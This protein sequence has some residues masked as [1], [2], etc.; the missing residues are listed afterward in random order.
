M[1]SEKVSYIPENWT[2]ANCYIVHGEKDYLIDPSIDFDAQIA[3]NLAAVIATHFHY[4]H[5]Q[6]SDV[7]RKR[8]QAEFYIPK[9][10]FPLLKDT[11]ANCSIMFGRPTVFSE[12]EHYFSDQEKFL[13]DR[14]LS[15]LAYH[16]PGHSPGSSVILV[17][18]TAEA[19]PIALISGDV[20]FADSIGRTDL[21]GGSSEAMWESLRRLIKIM[22]DL[23][24][25]LP[26]LP[27][28]GSPFK[29]KDAFHYNPY[30]LQFI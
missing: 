4:D 19:K 5:I 10:E 6:Q 15:F 29:I 14:E 13:A 9:A 30:I 21:K 1:R 7:W 24:A 27:G 23:P 22:R 28:H 25:D 8:A 18:E 16:L 12:P 2:H 17:R 26:V 3:K 11:E 20:L